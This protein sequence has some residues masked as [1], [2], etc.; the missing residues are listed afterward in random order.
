MMAVKILIKRK[1]K[2]GNM[3]AAARLLINHR[4]GAMA[5]PGYISS[6]TLRSLDDPTQVV[7]VSMWQTLEAWEAW[8]NSETRMGNENEF[9]DYLVD[10]TVYEHY[11]LG[12]PL[13]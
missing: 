6:E 8:K 4:K 1:I 11:S 7:V 5:Q 2:D 13:E 3:R 9:S 12:L 10:Q